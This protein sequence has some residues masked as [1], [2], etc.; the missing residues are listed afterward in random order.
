M[1][2]LCCCKRNLVIVSARH[3]VVEG[4]FFSNGKTVRCFES[5]SSV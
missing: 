2:D 4:G 5:I 3:V 1:L